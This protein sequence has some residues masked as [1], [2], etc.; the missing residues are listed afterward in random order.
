MIRARTTLSLLAAVGIL[1]P[2][3][4]FAR[5]PVAPPPAAA[6]PIALTPGSLGSQIVEIA[7]AMKGTD[8]TCA[9]RCYTLDH[10]TLRG[11]LKTGKL[12]FEL[13]GALLARGVDVSLFGTPDKVRL[14]N[15]TE[16]GVP[17]VV[18]FEGDRYFFRPSAGKFVLRGTVTVGDDR[19][20]QLPTPLNRFDSNITGGR[21]T[22]GASL[23]GLQSGAIHFD[24]EDATPA[25]APTIFS[26]SRAL[27]VKKSIEF[28]YRLTVQGGSDLGLVHLPLR[29]GEKITDVVGSTG[30]KVEGEDL[31]LPTTGNAMT[32]T[33]TGILTQLGS[34]SPDP[35]SP[36][37]WWLL[38][39]DQDHRLITS[40]D[41]KQHDSAES[42]IARREVSA[43]LFMIGKGQKLDVNLQTLATM[44]VLSAVVHRMDRHVVLTSSGDLV[45]QDT[46]SY[47]NSGI[48]YL[49]L[50]PTGKPL[51]LSIDGGSERLMHKDG[52]T[53]LMIPLRVG[54]HDVMTQSIDDW[55]P[56]FFGGRKTFVSPELP[57][58]TGRASLRLGLPADVHPMVVTG[59]DHT[60]WP[61][62]RNDGIALALSALLSAIALRGN[63]KRALGFASLAGLWFFSHPVFGVTLAAT[64]V[65]GA[66]VGI[67]KLS[68]RARRWTIGLSAAAAVV[69]IPFVFNLNRS[70][71]V[72]RDGTIAPAFYDLPA[73]QTFGGAARAGSEEAD[74]ADS[75]D[76][77]DGRR[78]DAAKN[79]GNFRA[80]LSQSG[81]IDGVRPVALAMPS[82]VNEVYVQTEMV[83][84]GKPFAPTVY[85][86]TDAGLLVLGLFWI[87]C[88]ASLGWSERERLKALREKMKEWLTPK[89]EGAST[90]APE[91]PAPEP[92]E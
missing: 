51:F 68:P 20:L 58:A 17:A 44:E 76:N 29:Y 41:A 89:P 1:A 32:V 52:E 21:V 73:G 31:V 50:T 11:D 80:Q 64:A 84:A 63:K 74:K 62:G 75:N 57:L 35:R 90:P 79:I 67:S 37:E 16:N 2:A 69:A 54:S 81:M 36:F 13:E 92:A 40:G 56:G 10:L 18:G 3:T 5:S 23:S 28:E 34:F 27:R 85:F 86:V 26:L 49:R 15:V 43:R 60:Q 82:S 19:T 72:T 14:E 24:S 39:S 71:D 78:D 47:E 25:P 66:V 22:E 38:E 61:V 46:Y 55:S 59:G 88:A 8:P 4:A 12:Q 6:A 65:T 42:P 87:G 53:A 48:D 91:A 70:H 9:A 30:W 45:S 7:D 77:L 33:V 83:S